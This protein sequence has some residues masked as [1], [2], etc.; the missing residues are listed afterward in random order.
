MD[1]SSAQRQIPVNMMNV[2]KMCDYLAFGFQGRRV[3]SSLSLRRE[4]LG[5][6]ES[7][8]LIVKE[9]ALRWYAARIGAEIAAEG[10]P[11]SESQSKDTELLET[12]EWKKASR[13]V[14]LS[15]IA[16]GAT[17]I[18]DC[19][20]PDF[21]SRFKVLYLQT[22]HMWFIA[23][24]SEPVQKGFSTLVEI[25]ASTPALECMCTPPSVE[26]LRHMAKTAQ[27]AWLRC[28]WE[29]C[30]SA[31][32]IALEVMI[33]RM[34]HALF[35][36]ESS[37]ATFFVQKSLAFTLVSAAVVEFESIQ[38]P[39]FYRYL[40]KVA[41]R[42][43]YER[44]WAA[45]FTS[46]QFCQPLFEPSLPRP[47]SAFLS[48]TTG[49]RPTFLA[50]TT[51]QAIESFHSLLK[52]FHMDRR[53]GSILHA[54]EA[55]ESLSKERYTRA[56]DSVYSTRTGRRQYG[57]WALQTERDNLVGNRQDAT[58]PSTT[59]DRVYWSTP[60]LMREGLGTQRR[61]TKERPLGAI[62]R[63]VENATTT[64]E[65]VVDSAIYEIGA[66]RSA[67]EASM[68]AVKPNPVSR[69]AYLGRLRDRVSQLT[70]VRHAVKRIPRLSLD[71]AGGM[72]GADGFTAASKALR[73]QHGK[74][75]LQK[76]W[77]LGTTP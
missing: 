14:H 61:A 37:A 21:L 60:R 48:V 62:L 56:I 44:N 65:H 16:A 10:T 50:E 63:E 47:V 39:K 31:F 33:C 76:R 70:E 74:G 13:M 20:M 5:Q 59:S 23:P 15:A 73:R 36:T 11:Q 53:A 41:F 68:T 7:L 38:A 71:A 34:V 52:E 49:R 77:N 29:A 25:K 19:L 51:N 42:A 35:Q 24:A 18:A 64:L 28:T 69:E 12:E 2:I 54:K 32:R 43:A 22:G 45:A 27:R 6:V 66:L 4:R 58:E 9:S 1:V 8:G 17:S 3:Q 40:E 46:R 57:R 26:Q 67:R 72:Q 75:A 30:P 55:L